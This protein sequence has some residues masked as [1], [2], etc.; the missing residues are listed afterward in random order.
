MPPYNIP[1]EVG[2]YEIQG[3]KLVYTGSLGTGKGEF[4]NPTDIC[5]DRSGRIYVTDSDAHNLKVF[6]P[7]G[8][9][10][11]VIGSQGTG[12]GYFNIPLS[13]AVDE[14]TG[15]IYVTDKQLTANSSSGTVSGARV[16][17][18]SEQGQYL[19]GFGRYL[20]GEL[21]SPS[22]IAL[23]NGK[24]YIADSYQNA[25]IVYD[26]S[27]G[28]LI[29]ILQAPDGMLR[30]PV[31][32]DISG[33]GV[34]HTV[35]T[36]TK[37]LYQVGLE[38]YVQLTVT[39]GLLQF[40]AIAGGAAPSV[41]DIT[42]G[43]TGSGTLQWTAEADRSWIGIQ[44]QAGEV[45]P[46]LSSTVP[47]RVDPVGLTEGVYEGQVTI[48][49][50]GGATETVAVSLTVLP[51]PVLTVSPQ[52]L[53]FEMTEGVTPAGQAIGIQIENALAE[54]KWKAVTDAAWFFVA[55]A[56]AGAGTKEAVV[57]ITGMPVPGEYYGKV[58]VES[59]G[60]VGSP[61]EVFVTLRVR[62]SGAITVTTNLRE[63]T[64]TISGDNGRTYTGSGKTWSVKGVPAGSYH[65]EFHKVSGY[66]SPAGQ[67]KTLASGG[68]IAFSGAYRRSKE[69]VVTAGSI[70]NPAEVRITDG[71]GGLLSVFSALGTIGK[72][73][74][75]ATGDI[76]GDGVKEI[77]VSLTGGA[78]ELGIFSPAGL[79]LDR[80]SAFSGT[81]GLYVD[82]AD[83]DGDGSAEIMAL[84]RNGTAMNIYRYEDGSVVDT[85][86]RLNPGGATLLAA[87]DL[88]G[89]GRDEVIT[90]KA[91]QETLIQIW[92]L[93]TGTSGWTIVPVGEAVAV[94]RAVAI[95]TG[96]LS[97]TG[98]S[99][100]LVIDRRG[101]LLVLESSG[102][103]RQMR[104]SIK[105][106]CDISTGDV[107]GRDAP[108]IIIGTKG[109]A[110]KIFSSAGEMRS[111]F[112]VH[113]TTTS[114]CIRVSAGNV[115]Y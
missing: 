73:R 30:L 110:V 34:L 17:V 79:Q 58:R 59:E 23:Y 104:L 88:D 99:D 91:A 97:A 78:N 53:L 87:G 102:G 95:A 90:A 14:S 106:A 70:N 19:R 48:R 7:D 75:I 76:D 22:D 77:I 74:D 89:D 10:I 8:V 26:T 55:P 113:D 57:Y 47:I 24:A 43:N 29:E 33:D 18:F 109:G 108:E 60:A 67:T 16:Q 101:R 100:I 83:L 46:G 64:Y 54:T 31:S 69:R 36:H 3:R 81:G 52:S 11:R 37:R 32:L 92:R 85:G 40:E 65:I 105:N 103:R 4:I 98:T 112:R 62:Q 93:Q 41:K 84:R 82:T 20:P 1:G 39:P 9:L 45:G 21:I 42:V 66:L 25:V 6:G 80:F 2:I 28:A 35:S 96:D 51:Q 56:E 86:L 15:D 5:I 71:G 49:S 68:S 13:V 44:L 38:G 27:S 115:G 63:A 111:G 72:G 50:A 12:D 61:S 107:S 94:M 114:S